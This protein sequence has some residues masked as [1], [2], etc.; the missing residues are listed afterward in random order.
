MALIDLIEVSKQ[1]GVKKILDKV[2]L[3]IYEKDAICL[4]GQ[5]G[6][7]KSTL[8]N[9]I[10]SNIA[11]DDGKV[12]VQS[13]LNI[14]YLEQNPI[15]EDG[16][17]VYEHLHNSLKYLR[18]IKKEFDEVSDRLHKEYENEKLLEHSSHLA[19]ILD[20]HDGWDLN[21]RLIEI[22][23]KFDL[24]KYKDKDI[25]L[26]SGG[27]KKRVSLA[28]LLL[29]NSD[30]LILDEPTNHLDVY[31]I[32]FLEEILMNTSHTILFVSHDRYFIDNVAKRMVEID[33]GEIREFKGGYSDYLEQ[34]KIL[35]SQ[36]EKENEAMLKILKKEEEW[37]AKGVKARRKRNEGRKANLMTL[38]EEVKKN[39]SAIRNMKIQLEREKQNSNTN[40]EKQSKKKMFFEIDDLVLKVNKRILVNKFTTRILQKDKIAIVGKNGTGKSTFLKALLGE[41]E[42]GGSIKKGDF[43]IG[44]FDQSKNSLDDTKT[45]LETFCP[46]GGDRIDYKG[47]N[48]HV[49]GYLKNFLFPKEFLSHKI[50]VLSG[51]EKTRVALALLLSQKKDI[52]IL[53]EPTNDLDIAT[54]NII[55]EALINFEGA[56]IFV[57]HDRYFVDKVAHKLFIIKDDACIEESVVNYSEYL[58]IEKS[59]KEMDDLESKNNNVDKISTEVKKEKIKQNNEKKVLSYKERFESESLSE[60]I[61]ILENQIKELNECL[62]KPDCYKDKGLNVL[63]K[64]LNE[65]T[66]LYDIKVERYLYLVS[67]M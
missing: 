64:E 63:S 55:E 2:S 20:F 37:L 60:D 1:Y 51:G 31:M 8:I 61:E 19:S 62:S 9:I 39:P 33:R 48:I 22:I 58:D 36:K 40:Q 43:T 26:L 47:S 28:S 54:I 45:L 32:S 56:L 30:I 12:I 24:Y 65:K 4:I 53:D 66:K 38:R 29:Q 27:E 13:K 15:F 21:N 52:L 42:Y 14:N 35:L 23:E 59:L 46:N 41:I 10:L 16:I 17:S 34:K 57:S 3:N 18:E 11:V 6:A 44:Y 25:N 5:N 50:G 67:Y 7:G 49:Y